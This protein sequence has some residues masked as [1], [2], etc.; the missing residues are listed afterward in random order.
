MT[1]DLVYAAGCPNV[2]EARTRLVRAFAEAGFAPRWREWLDSDPGC[3]SY[4][5]GRGSPAIFVD[6]REVAEAPPAAGA[7]CRVYTDAEG[8]LQRAPDVQSLVRAL[9]EAGRRRGRWARALAVL[10]AVGVAL[11]PKVAC[12]ACWPAYAGLLSSVGLGFLLEGPTLFALTSVFLA[13]ALLALGLRA[14]QRHGYAPLAVG[15]V[16]AAMLLAGKFAFGSDPALYL[17]VA[18][19]VAA[20]LWNSWPRRRREAECPACAPAALSR[21]GDAHGSSAS[22]RGLQRRVPGVRGDA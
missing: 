17:G 20:S 6:G 11:L 7:S 14:R 3:P 1:V 16:A 5:L 10:P 21:K 9:R 4:A 13:A 12:P 22:H 19:L 8:R 18:L 2:A 15:A